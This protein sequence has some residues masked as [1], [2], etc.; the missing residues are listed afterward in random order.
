M[1]A[2]KLMIVCNYAHICITVCTVCVRA[3]EY[4]DKGS[5]F[6]QEWLATLGHKNDNFFQSNEPGNT[7]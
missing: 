6:M 7:R 4:V 5:P 2:K 1:P 3:A